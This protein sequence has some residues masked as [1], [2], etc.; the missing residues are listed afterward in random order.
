[1]AE[2]LQ[3]LLDRINA[4]GIKK[5][6]MEAAR[7]I[8]NAKKQAQEIRSNA[9]TQAA[10]TV[11][12]AAEQAAVLESRAEAAIRQ[13]ARDVL[14]ELQNELQ[15]RIEKAVAGAAEEALT[16]QFMAGLIQSMAAQFAASPDTDLTVL[17]AVKDAAELDGILKSALTGSFCSQP[18][19]F[20][21]A[22]IKGGME[23]SFRDGKLYFDFTSDAITELV[24]AY[25]GP[26][27][28]AMLKD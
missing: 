3:S 13:A 12:D 17:A 28:G 18:R 21:S 7:I 27:L 9:E 19:V 24:A 14:L 22:G 16:P 20:A 25:I 26:R 15:K 6:E 8:E 11:R 1:M 2:E 5:A 10:A 23:V 4:E